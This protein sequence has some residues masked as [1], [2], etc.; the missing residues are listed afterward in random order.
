MTKSEAY[1]KWIA[2]LNEIDNTP[3]DSNGYVSAFTHENMYSIEVNGEFEYF[4]FCDCGER[5]EN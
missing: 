5:G 2:R 4:K 3:A 1:I